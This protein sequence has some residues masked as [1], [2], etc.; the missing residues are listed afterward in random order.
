MERP[1]LC[2]VGLAGVDAVNTAQLIIQEQTI[3]YREL[4]YS[5][6]CSKTN[7]AQYEL[8]QFVRMNKSS[9]IVLP[10]SFNQLFSL[11][12]IG[13]SSERLSLQSIILLL[14]ATKPL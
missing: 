8:V 13:V 1:R 14:S 5:L 9:T 12:Y 4:A 2:S 10:L 3:S 11:T 6:V 7:Y